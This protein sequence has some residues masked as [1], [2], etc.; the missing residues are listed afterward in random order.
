MGGEIKSIITG[1]AACQVRLLRIFTAAGIV[2]QEGYGLTEAAPIISGNY[3]DKKDR[4]FGTVG[5]PMN[6][7]AVKIAE[8]GEILCK[9]PNVMIGYYKRPD[10]TKEVMID[11]WLRTGDIG[12]F[13]DEKFLKITDR[14]KELLK[15]SGG[16]FVAPQ[17]IEN[18]MSE[19]PWI[20][21]IMV[22]GEMQ[23]FVS[24][25]IVP[26]FQAIKKWYAEQGKQYPGNDRILN[27]EEV[28][29]LIKDAVT[30]YN[31]EFNPVE[32]IKEFRLLPQEWTIEGG[33]LTP[34]LKL[35]RKKIGEKYKEYIDDIYS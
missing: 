32:Q 13:V 34:T 3:Y 4:K 2:I 12:T 26:A 5:P 8:D 33:E 14:K 17:P 35:K 21:Q 31:K 16:K 22:V 28:R 30:K 23:K 6:N 10:L 20:E 15:T 11:G 25:L 18:K 29:N 7:V 19:S 27:D 24:A 9:G 1:A